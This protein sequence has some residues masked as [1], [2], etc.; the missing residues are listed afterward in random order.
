L[1][2]THFY[3]YDWLV[4]QLKV[5]WIRDLFVNFPL[6]LPQNL[7][8]VIDRLSREVAKRG[9]RV[10]LVGGVVRDG[11][12]GIPTKDVDLEV[13]GLPPA[14]L[15]PV[16]KGIGKYA[17]VGKAFGV[18]KLVSN[19]LDVAVPRRERKTGE[20]HQAFDIEPDPFLSVAE[21]AARRDF[22]VNALYADPLTQEVIDPHGGWADL[23]ARRLR[24][25]SAAF[26]EDPLRVLRGMQFC[27]RFELTPAEETVALCRSMTPESLSPERYYEEWKK[28]ILR[29][30]KP[31]L[32]L[33]FLRA[34]G[35][36]QYFPELQALID[37][38]QDPKWHPEGDVWQ[39]TL[40][41]LDFFARQRIGDDWEDLVVG[42]AVLCHDL[43]KPATT[44]FSDG[45]WRS[46]RHDMA[47]EAPTRA[48]LARFT[49][50][51]DL[52]E[53]VVPLVLCH[54]RPHMLYQQQGGS[55]AI[56]RLSRDVGRLDRLIR[57]LR[58]DYGGRPPL[59]GEPCKAADWLAAKAEQLRIQDEAPK[60]IL[61]GRHLIEAGL[62]PGP[63]FKEIL[64]A[65]Y[66]A[67]LDD[68]FEDEAGALAFLRTYLQE[69]PLSSE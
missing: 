23:Q 7:A 20:G 8:S 49:Q 35:W 42:L 4:K 21:A 25:T 34:T 67:Q 63:R 48:L 3:I 14:Q 27:A 50:H 53:A 38:P 54:M 1:T 62:K 56:R 6:I 2:L 32:G 43:G 47:G 22:T 19:D 13:F 60:P 45:H 36:V 28:L 51:R 30:R 16:L 17:S 46:P 15:E 12:L 64:D 61:M 55:G 57:V 58:A 11:L 66:E 39:H 65:A 69:T 40:Y 37:C 29:G 10:L 59:P 24:H 26:V 18:Y 5:P 33:E 52:I 31:S 41:C 68:A 9:G 44:A